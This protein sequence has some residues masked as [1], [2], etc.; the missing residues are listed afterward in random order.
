[1]KVVI[2]GAAGLV[3]RHFALRLVHHH[4]VLALRR[5]D[6]DVT[7]R[8]AVARLIGDFQPNLLINGA[9]TQVDQAEEDPARCWSVNA[10]APEIL[11]QAVEGAGAEMVHFGTQYVFS[12]EPVGRAPYTV[13]D[14]PQP[15]NEYGRSKLAGEEAVQRS[16]ARSYV[17]RTAWVYG[18]G[19]NSFLCTVHD[20]L[21]AGKVVRAID[22]IW[23]N[24]TYVADL[25]DRCLEIL[26]RRV[27]GTYHV[28]N[29]G[30][31]TYYDFAL[32]AANLAGLSREQIDGLIEI[33][34]ERDMKRA[35]ARP[36]YT[37]LRCL[38]SEQLGLA[39]MRPWQAALAAYVRA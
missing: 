6:L 9:V 21:K 28:I 12:G 8:V 5:A 7:D 14:Q 34:H 3:A 19:K 30:V 27:Y 29:Q 1:M 38:L 4:E 37:P 18:S 17:I 31:C 13:A 2:T 35:A 11:A 23:S 39:P 25:I 32:A 10:A 15:V 24:T 36:R 20:D 33:T 16:C 22:D 26:Q